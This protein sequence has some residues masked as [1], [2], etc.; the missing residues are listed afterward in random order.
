MI[1]FGE[2]LKTLQCAGS[3]EMLEGHHEAAVISKY[4][5]SL[6]FSRRWKNKEMRYFRIKLEWARLSDFSE[7]PPSQIELNLE[8]F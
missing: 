3:A 5:D 1:G 4:A 8:D 6:L 7:F 2:M